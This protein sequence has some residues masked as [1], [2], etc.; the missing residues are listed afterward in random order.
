M[1]A[2]SVTS[3]IAM[4]TT[5]AT[6]R[7]STIGLVN[8]RSSTRTQPA[9]CR[10]P[11]AARCRATICWARSGSSPRREDP[12]DASTTSGATAQNAVASAFP[13]PAAGPM[14]SP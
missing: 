6:T 12:A 3:P 10:W 1:T 13:V 4:E 5:V 8:C 2:P 14:P 9:S 11:R 7:I